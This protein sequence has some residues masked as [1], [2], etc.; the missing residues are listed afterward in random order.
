ML[1]DNIKVSVIIPTFNSGAYLNEAINSVLNQTYSPIEIIVV[2]DGSTDSTDNILREYLNDIKYLSQENLGP[3]SARNLGIKHAKGEYIAFLDA[4]D[5]WLPEKIEK[6][7]DIFRKNPGTALV[8]SRFINFDDESGNDMGIFPDKVYSGFI[9]D[10]LLLKTTILLSTAIVKSSVLFA[11]GGFNE[12]LFT[13]ED[14]NLYLRIAKMHDISGMEQVLVKR[15]KH[16]S[17]LSDR[18]NIPVG[19][20]TNLDTIVSL[21]PETSPALYPPMKQAY[22]LKGKALIA[23]FFH[24]AEYDAC[25]KTSKRLIRIKRSDGSVL[26][27]YFVSLLPSTVINF[28]RRIKLALKRT[29][30]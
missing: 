15:R 10:K 20:L 28:L 1:K 22:F 23:D 11:V 29:K 3:A 24:A 16:R 7:V 19:T 5:I 12:N 26:G 13:A 17:N 2:N 27:Y 18:F 25:H 6:Q 9:F 8:Y 21:Y 14:T 4:D 30:D